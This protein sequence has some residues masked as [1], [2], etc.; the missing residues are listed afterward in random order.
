V[1][2]WPATKIQRL[3]PGARARSA[4]PRC[5]R[6][7]LSGA[8]P[9]KGTDIFQLLATQIPKLRKIPIA[10]SSSYARVLTCLLQTRE[11]EQT[12]EALD[13][14]LFFPSIAL[15]APARGGKAT[16]ASSAQQ[17]RLNCLWSVLDPLEELIARVKRATPAEDPRTRARTRAAASE[18]TRASSSQASD[19]TA[20]AVRA[21]L[22]E[23]VAGRALQL[24][25][26]D[27]A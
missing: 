27:G 1:L 6:P 11:R 25:T 13:R 23:G 22:G 2:A 21:L 18:A 19:R 12:W 26:S 3:G 16:R 14:L 24:L 15:A 17:C 9:P 8:P 5:W 20:A 4:P 10:A 7:S